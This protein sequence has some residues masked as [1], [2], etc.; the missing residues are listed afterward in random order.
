MRHTTALLGLVTTATAGHVSI[1]FSREKFSH[2]LARLKRDDTEPLSLEALNNLTGGGYYSEFE[3]GTPPQRINF[4]L[5]TG[6][7]DT[8]ANSVDADLCND[9]RMQATMGFCQTQCM[10]PRD[11]NGV[12]M[13]AD[14][15]L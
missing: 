2:P 11:I 12:A 6:S 4:L 7:S 3:I 5:D 13:V 10:V 15:F 8:W 14:G 1:P 9:R